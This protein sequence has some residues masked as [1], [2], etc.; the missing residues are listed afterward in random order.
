M[1]KPRKG[2][3]YVSE[4]AILL[5]DAEPTLAEIEGQPTQ[6]KRRENERSRALA[7]DELVMMYR[8]A[9]KLGILDRLDPRVRNFCERLKGKEGKFGRLPR[10]KGG[11]PR[12]PHR[13]LLIEITVLEAIEAEG[14]KRGSVERAMRQAAKQFNVHYRRVREI[15]YDRD[16]DWK[17]EVRVTRALR[18]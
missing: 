15:H 13:R 14:G 6:R 10:P 7:I 3:K 9:A 16:P 5:R 2:T 1:T 12:D 17:R 11:R 4:I 8:E 18:G